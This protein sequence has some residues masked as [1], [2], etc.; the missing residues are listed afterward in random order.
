MIDPQDERLS[1]VRQ[2][3]LVGITRLSYYYRPA[4][5]SQTN[6]RLMLLM[7]ELQ[8]NCPWYRSWQM[9]LSLPK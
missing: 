7:D 9:A 6:L 1:L 4:G 8:L 5:E 3:A 2:C